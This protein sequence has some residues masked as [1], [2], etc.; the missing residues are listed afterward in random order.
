MLGL[1]NH[2]MIIKL[3]KVLYLQHYILEVF[4]VYSST[5]HLAKLSKYRFGDNSSFKNITTSK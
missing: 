2:N 4:H 3:L 5:A 1:F